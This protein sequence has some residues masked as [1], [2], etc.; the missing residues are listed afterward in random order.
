MKAAKDYKRPTTIRRRKK[1]HLQ[2]SENTNVLCL[3]M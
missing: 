1:N 2:K 3:K